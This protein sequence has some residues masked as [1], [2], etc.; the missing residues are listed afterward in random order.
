MS[1]HAQKQFMNKLL[2]I[3]FFLILFLHAYFVS[4]MSC[5]M[6]ESDNHRKIVG[7]GYRRK[8]EVNSFQIYKFV[9]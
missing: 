2:S 3:S 5:I 4:V 6:D 9:L 1:C 7:N 8:I